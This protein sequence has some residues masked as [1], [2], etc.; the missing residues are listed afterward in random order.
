MAFRM[1]SAPFFL[2][3]LHKYF[4]TLPSIKGMLFL[5]MNSVGWIAMS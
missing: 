4:K 2:R 1:S 3:C 5:W